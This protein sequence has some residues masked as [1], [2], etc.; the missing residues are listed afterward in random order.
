MD[1]LG[2][3]L[4]LP[5]PVLAAC[6]NVNTGSTIVAHCGGWDLRPGHTQICSP[7]LPGCS[8]CPVLGF[9]WGFYSGDSKE[10]GSKGVKNPSILSSG[11]LQV[12]GIPPF[13]NFL[14]CYFCQD[15]REI[16]IWASFK[17]QI[18]TVH[19]FLLAHLWSGPRYPQEEFN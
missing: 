8:T 4:A 7:S 12:C 16:V 17:C 14:Q 19:H 13:N 5:G 2:A 3:A 10:E 15:D 1:A 6:T 18:H 9:L 11:N